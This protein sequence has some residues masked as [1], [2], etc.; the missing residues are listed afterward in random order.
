MAHLP[1]QY[2]DRKKASSEKSTTTNKN[3]QQLNL[4]AD[5]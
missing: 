5:K 4:T 3:I 1:H 2:T